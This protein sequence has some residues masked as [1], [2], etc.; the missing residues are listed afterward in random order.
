MSARGSALAT[1][2]APPD[3]RALV[4]VADRPDVPEWVVDWCRRARRAVR[5]QPAAGTPEARI[6]S[7]A[8]LAG[9]TVLVLRDSRPYPPRAPRVV[10][11]VRDLGTDGAVLGEAAD[12]AE[13]LGAFL[14]V[15]HTVPLSF[16]ERSVGLDDAVARGRR[17]L[18]DAADLVTS[19]H[20]GRTVTTR[21][22]RL[23]PHELVG[24]ELDADLLVLSGPRQRIP[25]RLGLVACSALQH[26]PCP[27]LLAPRPA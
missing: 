12:A 20:P 23:H 10:A 13:Q 21:L 1:R 18:A 24:E 3:H 26:A 5:I 8:S 19:A 16:G 2:Q 27:V 25:A 14:L 15:A 4:V 9:R 17:L 7:I 11:A 6:R 22:L